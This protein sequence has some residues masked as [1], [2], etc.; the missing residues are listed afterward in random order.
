MMLFICLVSFASGVSALIFE[1]LWFHQAGLVF[2]NSVWAT[3]TTLSSFM[4]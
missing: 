2:G 4:G 1:I 3:S